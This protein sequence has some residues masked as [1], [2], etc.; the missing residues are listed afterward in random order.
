MFGGFDTLSAPPFMSHAM[1]STFPDCDIAIVG[2][3]LVGASLAVALEGSG[4]RTVLLEASPPPAL[5]A[6][7]DER[8]IGLN[9]ATRRIFEAWGVWPAMCEAAAPILATQVSEQGRFGTARFHATEAGLDALGFNTP[10]RA[11]HAA[12]LRPVRA[13]KSAALW[14]PVRV[15]GVAPSRDD[16]LLTLD[17]GRS[18]RARL[19]VAADGARSPLRAQFG[20]ATAVRD[21][22]QSAIVSSVEVER[23]H[24]GVA[25][26]RFTPGGP[27]AV[28]PRPGRVCTVVWTQPAAR[29]EALLALDDDAFLAALQAAFGYRLGRFLKLGRR[30]AYPLSRVMSERLTAERTVFV[31]NAAQTLHP[32]VAQGFNLGL[33]DVATLA[34]LLR[35]AADPGAPALLRCYADRRR[36]DRQQVAAFTDRLVRLFAS[37]WP[38]LREWRHLGLAALN[39]AGPVKQRLMRRSLGYG[40]YT[41]A[42]AR[43]GS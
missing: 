37:E 42:E 26:E 35:E 10:L 34:E 8:C 23:A 16:A 19:V 15:E 7:W 31:G 14:A 38:G 27:L 18:L 28:L 1:P 5:A 39:L 22:G 33:R 13:S 12:L 29:A 25:Y 3:G 36:E 17:D 4:L 30:S 21:Y 11:I 20:I 43:H 40:G 41:P 6:A 9:D 24:D 32:V 2:G